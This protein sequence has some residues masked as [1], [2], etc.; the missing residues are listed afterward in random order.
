MDRSKKILKGLLLVL[1]VGSVFLFSANCVF[2]DKGWKEI[3]TDE[4]KS[5]IDSG[6]DFVLID[7]R[8]SIFHDVQSIPGSINIP[9][10]ELKTSSLL[11]KEKD[12]IIVF[13]C[14]GRG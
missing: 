1:I 8:P 2:A 7:V 9:L 5:W 11:P 3:S 14:M 6:K 10:G 13:Y 4:L 12:K